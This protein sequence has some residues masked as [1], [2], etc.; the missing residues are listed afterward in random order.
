MS[1]H[2]THA[3]IPH[4]QEEP[5]LYCSPEQQTPGYYARTQQD[6]HEGVYHRA[7]L[8]ATPFPPDSAS[9]SE[10]DHLGEQGSPSHKVMTNT[11]SAAVAP[12]CWRMMC[13]PLSQTSPAAA[14]ANMRG[15]AE[16]LCEKTFTHVAAPKRGYMRVHTSSPPGAAYEEL[17]ALRHGP[18]P[19]SRPAR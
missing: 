15:I 12:R 17:A 16:V 11:L 9:K 4:S 19:T 13:S 7:V 1:P 6:S 10:D 5:G 2:S 14:N 18:E 8:V 3:C